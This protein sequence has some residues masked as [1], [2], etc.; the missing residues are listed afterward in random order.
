MILSPDM[1]V[2]LTWKSKQETKSSKTDFMSSLLK[3]MSL[4]GRWWEQI[5]TVSIKGRIR[6]K[7]IDT[8]KSLNIRINQ[9]P[10]L[11]K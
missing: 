4:N 9:Q 10:T 1:G 6:L 8:T 7:V 2:I 5:L 3:L 11:S